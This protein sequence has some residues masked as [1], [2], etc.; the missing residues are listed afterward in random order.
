MRYH[1]TSIGVEASHKMAETDLKRV[2]Q[3]KAIIL[4]VGRAKQMDPAVIAGIISKETRGG[5]YLTKEGFQKVGKGFGLMQVG[6]K[7]YFSNIFE[8]NFQLI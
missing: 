4:K 2:D 5:L 3:Y 6:L 1:F 8:F 7:Q